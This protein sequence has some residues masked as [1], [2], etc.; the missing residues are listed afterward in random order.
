MTVVAE[1]QS[2]SPPYGA[3]AAITG[4][5]LGGLGV[6]G[7]AARALDR[8]PACQ[9]GLDLIVLSACNTAGP[10]AKTGESLS[11]LAR[12][13][14]YAG[15]SSVVSTLWD[16]ADEPASQLVADFYRS[17]ANRTDTWSKAEALRAA[18]LHLLRSLRNGEVRVD[19]PFG[20][21]ALPEDPILWAGFIVL[22]EP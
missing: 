18:E 4:V 19:T 6:A 5:F 17:F 1:R 11:G 22:G 15:A 3:Y 10:S 13:F 7:V 20:K 2:T 12:A 14:F 21:V 16:V 9:T 8:D